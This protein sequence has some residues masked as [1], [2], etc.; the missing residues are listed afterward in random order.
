MHFFGALGVVMFLI[1]FSLAF[2]LGID[3]LFVN[4]SAKLLAERTEVFIALTSMIIGVQFFLAGF[5]AEML[6]RN[7][8]TR[9][10]YIVEKEL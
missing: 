2:Y 1:G 8:S 4:K 9:N 10:H 3:K 6:G 5:L 7:S